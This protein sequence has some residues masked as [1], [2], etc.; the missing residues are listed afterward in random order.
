MLPAFLS[1]SGT[2]LTADERGLFA[3]VDPAGYVLFARN[4][5]DRPQLK[6]LT[7]SLRD[8]AGRSDLPILIDQEGGRIARLKPPE[9][10]SFPAAA[11]FGA[12][13]DVA[14]ISAIEAARVNAL[15][16]GLILAEV[17]I[18][19]DCFP[20][21]DLRI[22]GAHVIIGDRSLGAA[23]LA[24]AALG[25]AIL[26]G[27]AA[28]GVVGVVKHVPGHGR[29]A[30]DSHVELPHVDCAADALE[31]DIAPFRSLRDAPMAMTAHVLYRAW[32]PARC[33]TLSPAVI[34]DVI[35][36]RI[37]FDGLLMSDDIGMEALAGPLGE[38]ARAAID[39][40]CDIVLHCSGRIEDSRAVAA[41]LPPIGADAAERL[42][43]AMAQRAPADPG[44]D[45]AAL[46][47]KRDALL[48]YVGSA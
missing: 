34:G 23:P 4:C 6:A 3:D 38:R 41:A 2:T 8:L 40:G 32:D 31:Q 5:G 29:A 25:R 14:P 46:L 11:T 17:G 26:D 30:S 39:A 44:L 21:L 18:S 33:A 22:E 48:A 1:L 45:L 27:L 24:V 19:V 37:G 35:R 7:D 10:P 42:A 12:L 36:G 47:A 9:W 13:Y 43:R 28:G 15:A 20:S 16:I